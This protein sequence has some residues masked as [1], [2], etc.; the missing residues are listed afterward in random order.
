MELFHAHHQWAK[1]PNDERFWTL[2]QMLTATK[3]YAD[4]AVEAVGVD[5]GTL[6]VQPATDDNLA[7]VGK[8]GTPAILSNWSF[9]QLCG[10]VGAPPTYLS[11]LPPALA[12]DNLNHGLRERAADPSTHAANLLLHR[13]NGDMVLRAVTTDMYERLWNWEVIERLI[14]FQTR[15]DLIP[16]APTFSWSGGGEDKHAAPALYASD[17]DMFAFLMNKERSVL[18]SDE[19]LFRGIIVGNSEVGGSSLFMMWF[20]FRD[21]CMNHIIWGASEVSEFRFRHVGDLRGKWTDLRGELIKYLESDT[22][23]EV[24]MVKAAQKLRLGKDKEEV[25]DFL[26][27]QRSLGLS[28]KLLDASYEAVVP[29]QDGSPNTAWGMVQGMTRHAQ[30]VPYGD[31]RTAIDRS[32]AKILKQVDF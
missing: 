8:K 23:K 11:T 10:R 15:H 13:A 20:L 5:W 24:Q 29:E 18:G 22:T 21:I 28:R 7:L 19:G 25:L 3:S 1:R 6:A 32:A 14:D 9:N 2:P 30:T 16:A 31:E 26:F 12:A 17:H 4:K 27:G